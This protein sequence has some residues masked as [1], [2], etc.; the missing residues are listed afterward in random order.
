MGRSL[1]GTLNSGST[2]ALIRIWALPIFRRFANGPATYTGSAAGFD[3][4]LVHTNKVS[5]GSYRGM[6][7]PQI[8]WAIET[9]MDEIAE[10]LG[11]DKLDYRIEVANR[12]V[13]RPPRAGA[14]VPAH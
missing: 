6:G 14:L 8:I 11:R 13:M 2:T 5:G 9:Q 4:K 7:A 3:G 12:P 1:V 10:K